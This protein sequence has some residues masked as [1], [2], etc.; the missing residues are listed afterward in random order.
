M[1]VVEPDDVLIMHA[2]LS[3]DAQKFP[4]VDFVAVVQ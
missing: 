2:R 1:R 3:L 4:G